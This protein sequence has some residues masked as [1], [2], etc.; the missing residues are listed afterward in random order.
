MAEQ[1]KPSVKHFIYVNFFSRQNPKYPHNVYDVNFLA[2][3]LILAKN[4]FRSLD[5]QTNKNFEMVFNVSPK[6]FSSRHG[7]YKFVFTT[8]RSYSTLPIKFMATR[9]TW[10]N[11]V[12][13]AINKYDFVI[14]SRMD[15]DDFI[16]KGAVEDTQSKIAECDSVLAYGYCKGYLYILGELAPLSRNVKD[17]NGHINILESLILKS[18]V[19]REMPFKCLNIH[20]FFHHKFKTM[21]KETFEKNNI[22]FR[23]NMFLQNTSTNAY[24]YYRHDFSQEKLVKNRFTVPHV[25]LN[26]SDITKKQLE[27]E[28]GFFYDLKSIE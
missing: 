19:V 2:T 22:E 10:D 14:Q 20:S 13:D 17:G 24:I 9:E 4:I 27:E 18:S 12:K 25:K 23:E 26:G 28:F 3:Q 5:N 15:I 8:L 1:I 6:V 11:L 16:Y 7:K 21:M